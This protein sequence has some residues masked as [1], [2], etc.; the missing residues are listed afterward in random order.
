MEEFLKFTRFKR[1]CVKIQQE[2]MAS[3]CPPPFAHAHAD[4]VFEVEYLW[5][6]LVKKDGVNSNLV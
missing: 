6:D 3:P 4:V 5:G 2:A 1:E